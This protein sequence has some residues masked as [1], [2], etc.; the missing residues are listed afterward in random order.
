MQT[1]VV[2]WGLSLAIRLPKRAVDTLGLR[3]GE[4][5]TM[6]MEGGALVIRRS[7]PA[8]RLKDLVSQ[9][10]KQRAPDRFDDP[11]IGSEEL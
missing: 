11:A 7:G 9:A 4:P 1:R 3:P 2:Q 10:R 8:Y 6:D 5:I